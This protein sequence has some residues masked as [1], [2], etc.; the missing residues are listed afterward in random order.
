MTEWG[1]EALGEVFLHDVAPDVVRASERFNGA[2]GHGMF[3]ERWPLESWPNVP[4][5]VL[6]PRDDRLFPWE[7]Q[8]RVVRDRLGVDLDEISGGHLP[9]LSRPGKLAQRLVELYAESTS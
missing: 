1:E 4:T 3:T 2:P 6:C 5:R 8:E 9:M 7:F